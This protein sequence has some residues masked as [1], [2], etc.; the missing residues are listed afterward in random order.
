[1]QNHEFSKSLSLDSPGEVAYHQRP[2]STL[3]YLCP[4][5]SYCGDPK[6]GL[7]ERQRKAA[8]AVE[9]R[10]VFLAAV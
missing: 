9:A 7:A 6:A 5:D 4:I 1:M 8:H 2:H 3:K 10:K